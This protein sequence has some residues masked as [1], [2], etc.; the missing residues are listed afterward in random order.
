[1]NAINSVCVCKCVYVSVILT[2]GF[3][4]K[5]K[6]AGAIVKMGGEKEK[7]RNFSAASVF[8]SNT[9]VNNFH[10]GYI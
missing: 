6:S 3:L 1:M 10:L 5:I 4:P 7:N 2:V 8:V 9:F